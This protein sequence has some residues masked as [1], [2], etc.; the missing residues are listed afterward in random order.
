MPITGANARMG[1]RLASMIELGLEDALQGNIKVMTYDIAEE[2]RIPI[3]VSKLKARGTMLVLGPI[4]S[5]NAQEIIPQ[6]QPYGIT[7]ITFS[8]NPALASQNVFVFGHA[9]MKQTQRIID[10]TLAHGYKDYIILLPASKY[11]REMANIV[12]NMVQEKGENLC[13]ASFIV[14]NKNPS[15]LQCR[16]SR[17]WFIISMSQKILI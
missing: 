15:M 2:S 9:P 6:I 14:I 3:V 5:A 12:G 8:N 1:Q 16:I 10:Y 7:M 13:K 4:F 11:S 17:L